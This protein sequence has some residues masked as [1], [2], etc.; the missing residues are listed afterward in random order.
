MGLRLTTSQEIYWDRVAVVYDEPLPSAA[1]HELPLDVA[2]LR[3]S[4]FARRTTGPQ[5]T[6][7]YDYDRR[8]PLWDTRHP[9]GWYTAFG[10]VAPL[11]LAADD[12]VAIIG[13]GEEVVVEFTAPAA[14]VPRRLDPSSRAAGA[15]LVQGHGPLHARR[16]HGGAPAR[17]RH[18]SAH[19]VA[20]RP[21]NTRFESGR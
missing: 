15:R 13:P 2:S 19:A 18:G 14:A 9:R 11:V 21:F 5:R 1:V 6:P 12:A 7:A 20:C 4:G 8:A 16:R 17:R 10:D 3:E